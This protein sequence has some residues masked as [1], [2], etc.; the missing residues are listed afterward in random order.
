MKVR[1]FMESVW[2]VSF[3]R[4]LREERAGEGLDS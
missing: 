3:E 2:P 1:A 4:G